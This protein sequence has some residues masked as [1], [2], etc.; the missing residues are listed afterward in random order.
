MSPPRLGRA[1]SNPLFFLA[2]SAASRAPRTTTFLFRDPGTHRTVCTAPFCLPRSRKCEKKT[3]PSKS[4]M[5]KKQKM[6][7]IQ[8]RTLPGLVSE[9]G[10]IKPFVFEY[11]TKNVWGWIRRLVVTLQVASAPYE[12]SYGCTYASK[13]ES[14]NSHYYCCC[15]TL[16]CRALY[17][18]IYMHTNVLLLLIGQKY[19]GHRPQKSKQIHE[20]YVLG[21]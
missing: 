19:T 18:Y 21:T 8:T 9:R 13:F 5:P 6:H 17:I 15:T 1:E 7:I 2:G 20:R 3:R 14:V 12:Y 16:L 4:S 10:K 11:T